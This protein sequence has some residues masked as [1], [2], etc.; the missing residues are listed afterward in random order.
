MIHGLK[1][2]LKQT[3]TGLKMATFSAVLK[4]VLEPKTGEI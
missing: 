4:A 2:A 1:R 3:K